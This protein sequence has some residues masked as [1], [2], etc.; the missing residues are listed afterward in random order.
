MGILL[1]ILLFMGAQ[2]IT[3]GENPGLPAIGSSGKGSPE[4]F[5]QEAMLKQAEHG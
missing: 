5:Q 3:E 2:K 4:S 1:T